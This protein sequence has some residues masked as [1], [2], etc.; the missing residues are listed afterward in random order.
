[1]NIGKSVRNRR[2]S[3]NWVKGVW[4]DEKRNNAHITI[5]RGG[6]GDDVGMNGVYSGKWNLDDGW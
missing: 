5:R 6:E 2:R 3:V 1:M 4:K